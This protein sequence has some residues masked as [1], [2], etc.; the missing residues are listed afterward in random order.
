MDPKQHEEANYHK[1]SVSSTKEDQM[2][3]TFFASTGSS[4]QNQI[5]AAE[6]TKDF[7]QWNTAMIHYYY[8]IYYYAFVSNNIES[9]T[10]TTSHN[11]YLVLP[12][13]IFHAK[14]PRGVRGVPHL[15]HNK[16]CLIS[17]Y[18]SNW[19]HSSF[20][21]CY[22]ERSVLCIG[23]CNFSSRMVFGKKLL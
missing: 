12:R 21:R 10:T 22:Y 9:T 20:S 8:Y 11:N 1:R 4:Q 18:S 7:T 2:L 23:V 6:L 3:S 15:D 19:F 16:C 13:R 17:L 14:P 5:T